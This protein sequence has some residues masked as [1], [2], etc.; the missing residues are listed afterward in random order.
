MRRFLWRTLGVESRTGPGT[1]TLY[2]ARFPGY[3]ASLH[4]SP[5]LWRTHLS[6]SYLSAFTSAPT[7]GT[8]EST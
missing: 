7:H 3:K 4:A 2:R 1:T 6:R 8:V 5:A